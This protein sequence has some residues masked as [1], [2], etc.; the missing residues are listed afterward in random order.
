MGKLRYKSSDGYLK[1]KSKTT[2][3]ATNNNLV[4]V[5]S[6]VLTIISKPKIDSY[7]FFSAKSDILCALELV[8]WIVG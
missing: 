2:I 1:N 8:G 7:H 6:L 5:L 3:R 4:H